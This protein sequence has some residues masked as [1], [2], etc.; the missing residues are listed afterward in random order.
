M[1]LPQRV[2]DAFEAAPATGAIAIGV[3]SESGALTLDDWLK[4]GGLAF[5]VMQA[6]Y[7]LWRWWRDIKRD[8][9]GQPPAGE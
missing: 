1:D 6:L 8:R 2:K 7:L 4:I 3:A 5:L 9:A